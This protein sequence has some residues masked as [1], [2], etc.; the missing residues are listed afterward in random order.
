MTEGARPAPRAGPRRRQGP[1]PQRRR[2]A[3]E[4]RRS[5]SWVQ[6][7]EKKG[8]LRASPNL[9]PR[10]SSFAGDL[11]SPSLPPRAEIKQHSQSL[12]EKWSATF[13]LDQDPISNF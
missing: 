12:S 2:A 10:E 9:R 13:A 3:A 4:L 5:D 8:P 1:P 6:I 11:H 7:K